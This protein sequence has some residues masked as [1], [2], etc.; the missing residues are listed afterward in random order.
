[1]GKKIFLIVFIFCTLYSLNVLATTDL[2]NCANL[3]IEGETYNLLNNISATPGICFNITAADVVLDC[4][5]YVVNSSV[6]NENEFIHNIGY[7]FTLKNCE[8]HSF[9]YGVN[10]GNTEDAL[11]V[12]NFF[13]NVEYVFNGFGGTWNISYNNFTSNTYLFSGSSVTTAYFTN[14]ILVY[15]GS[16]SGFAPRISP[17]Y[18]SLTVYMND[19][20]DGASMGTSFNAQP[21]TYLNVSFNNITLTGSYA[22]YFSNELISYCHLTKPIIQNN[23]GYGGYPIYYSN[24]TVSGTLDNQTFADII[25]CLADDS[26][27]NNVTLVGPASNKQGS[28]YVEWSDNVEISNSNFTN[29]NGVYVNYY[30]NVSVH[31]NIFRCSAGLYSGYGNVSFFNN[32]INCTNQNYGGGV[33]ISGGYSRVFDNNFSNYKDDYYY[34]ISLAGANEIYNNRIDNVSNGIKV[35][36]TG[37]NV[38]F[39]SLTNVKNSLILVYWQYASYCNNIIQNNTGYGGY[40]IYYSNETVSGTLD[41]QTFADILLCNASNSILNNVTILGDVPVSYSSPGGLHVGFSNNVTL[42]NSTIN[43]GGG[44]SLVLVNDSFIINNNISFGSE[45]APYSYM[46]DLYYVNATMVANNTFSYGLVKFDYGENNTFYNNTF[47]TP[48]SYTCFFIF[49]G[50]S[51]LFS[52]NTGDCF[53]HAFQSYNGRYNTFYNNSLTTTA[54]T[55]WLQGNYSTNSI[56]SDAFNCP[57][58]CVGGATFEDPISFG[59][60]N[61]YGS[62]NWSVTNFSFANGPITVGSDVFLEDNNVGLADL[63]RFITLNTSANV[64]FK[65]LVYDLQPLLLKNGVICDDNPELCNITS[66][67]TGTLVAHVSGFSNYTTQAQDVTNYLTDC[68]DVSSSGVYVLTQNVNSTEGCFNVTANDVIFDCNNSNINHSTSTAG[69]AFNISGTNFTIENCN[70]SHYV[71]VSPIADVII[72]SNGGVLQNNTLTD[73]VSAIGA[74]NVTIQNNSLYDL[75]LNESTNFTLENNLFNYVVPIGISFASDSIYFNHSIDTTNTYANEPIYY[76]AN[77][78]SVILTGLTN[79]SQVIIAGC[80]NVTVKDS[81]INLSRLELYDVNNS[82]IQNNSLG[83]S[84]LDT[85]GLYMHGWVNNNTVLENNISSQSLAVLISN[86]NGWANVTNNIITSSSVGMRISTAPYMN[87]T[88]NVI[89]TLQIY[90]DSQYSYIEINLFSGSV[91]VASDN[92]TLVN[93]NVSFATVFGY[94]IQVVADNSVLENNIIN[95]TNSPSAGLFVEDALN[96]S[97]SGGQIVVPHPLLYKGIWSFLESC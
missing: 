91:I 36:G 19:I 13:Y 10:T 4:Q 93:N 45:A 40:P 69:Y 77:N 18:G 44:V 92:C 82:I 56:I 1:M 80:D 95:L 81:V 90:S 37:N 63:E 83:N 86:S 41:N 15:G 84:T 96:T 38:S 25:L 29:S 9:G 59:F 33:E 54:Q 61:V 85:Y 58:S 71:D 34:A 14:N 3:D 97:Y 67:D 17:T 20:Q 48:Y 12:N 30:S 35:F 5:G 32:D 49:E 65:G 46:V 31:D 57:S 78:D 74:A 47:N 52:S 22:R 72:E 50:N 21:G 8:V 28:L 75:T 16:F 51:S 79:V 73:S 66:W 68:Q 39:N 64:T 88:N 60:D 6:S 70:I 76:I 87:V 26:T 42:I 53:D 7:N 94:G 43:Q 55:F 11:L 23:T 24:E 2:T 62:I 27:L 89:S